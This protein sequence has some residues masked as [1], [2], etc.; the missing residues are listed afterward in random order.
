[1]FHFAHKVSVHFV[2]PNMGE[3]VSNGKTKN[4][5]SFIGS[6]HD[7]M[8]ADIVGLDLLV[9]QHMTHGGTEY[10]LFLDAGYPIGT[11]FNQF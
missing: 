8:A 1:M 2:L 11:L 10:K 9:Q 3:G 6:T 5:F 7:A 4:T